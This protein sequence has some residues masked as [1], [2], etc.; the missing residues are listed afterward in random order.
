MLDGW[1][2]GW[3]EVPEQETDPSV[4]GHRVAKRGTAEG[5][6]LVSPVGRAVVQK[7]GGKGCGGLF[8][9]NEERTL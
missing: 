4:G 8:V 6:G 2:R 1:A 9:G 3:V 5:K 7:G